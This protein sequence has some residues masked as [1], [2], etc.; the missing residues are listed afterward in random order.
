M[1]LRRYLAIL[2]RRAVLIVVTVLLAITAAVL[3]LNRTDLYR[4]TSVLYVGNRQISDEPGE[5]SGDRAAGLDR[6]TQTF[7]HMIDSEP[8]I[9][10]AIEAAG[11][12]RDDEDVVDRTTTN[13]P[14]LTS[15]IEITVIDEDPQIAQAL[16]NSI[17]D[18]FVDEVQNFEPAA[19]AEEGALPSLPAYVFERA[20]SPTDPIPVDPIRP[21]VLAFLVGLLLSAGAAFLLEYLDITVKSSEEAETKLGLPVLG[22]IP[23]LG[24]G[25]RVTPSDARASR[26]RLPQRRPLR[27]A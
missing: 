27:S 21:V 4:A 15:L 22:V 5:L 24:S 8:I 20:S 2:R 1:E 23:D 25:A 11:V 19:P 13:I 10:Q 7:S 12:S 18:T 3:T 26:F 16:A 14:L 17:A 6:V 9:Q